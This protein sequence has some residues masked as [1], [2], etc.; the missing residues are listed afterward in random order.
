MADKI[1]LS[2]GTIIDDELF[3]E[4][5]GFNYDD[6]Y[7]KHV[8]STFPVKNRMAYRLENI[9]VIN[10]NNKVDKTPL[11]ID[12]IRRI[13][14]KYSGYKGI[15]HC[16]SYENMVA[17]HEGLLTGSIYKWLDAKRSGTMNDYVKTYDYERFDNN[18]NG[19]WL[20]SHGYE[21]SD[22]EFVG[23]DVSITRWM[24]SD[25]PSVYLSV[26]FNEGID[27]KYDLCRYNILMKVPYMNLT[28]DRVKK[29]TELGHW[30]WYRSKAI[31]RLVQAYG[32]GV[33]YDDD[34]CDFYIIDGAFW[35]LYK[36]NK[37]AFPRY[38]REA[39]KYKSM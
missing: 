35:N 19:V 16:H 27:L 31:E 1:I 24:E 5:C 33:R 23:R 20:Q 39:L 30:R 29:R 21:S 28:D 7:F 4:E 6:C 32:R 15:V 22:E 12:T 34:W 9:G 37:G 14:K 10:N 26:N 17:V 25:E 13:M 36:T 11:V 38:F 3:A 8:G 2:S 18:V